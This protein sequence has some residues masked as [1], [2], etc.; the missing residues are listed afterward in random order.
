MEVFTVRS[1]EVGALTG[2][3]SALG[4]DVAAILETVGVAP[5]SLTDPLARFPEALLLA[6]WTEAEGRW[7][8]G[9]LGLHAGSHVP[10]G[11]LEVMDYLPGA[12]PTI[13]AG[14]RRL[15]EYSAI[16]NTGMTYAISDAGAGPVSVTMH[17][18]Y[19]FEL[20]PP[21]MVEYLWTLVVTRF[22]DHVDARF[23]PT[24]R[25]R[26]G[27]EG[28]VATYRRVL[29]DVVFHAERN[30]LLVPRAQWDLP[31]PRN[32]ASLA[33]VLEHHADDLVARLPASHDPLDAV[34]AAI[35]ASLRAGETTIE[36]T[37]ARLRV[38][39]RTLQRQLAAGQTTYRVALDSV[40][41]EVAR[42]MLV[43]TD[44]SLVD[45][46]YSLGYSDPSAFNRAF[47]RWT[48]MTPLAYRRSGRLGARSRVVQG[49]EPARAAR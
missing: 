24:L 15:A 31:N 48:G 43:T 1:A 4:L 16:V 38:S 17:H 39:T 42:A 12:S 5:A 29:G 14:L 6:I 19:A 10:V 30:E 25:L 46:A 22:R 32:D 40:R 20:L 33:R 18:P 37:A 47:R 44:R 9:Q 27:P 7:S 26:H 49:E 34:R 11:A 21:S 41:A 2:G 13:G 3:L 45:L 28:P 23:R 8:T 35:G 36:Q